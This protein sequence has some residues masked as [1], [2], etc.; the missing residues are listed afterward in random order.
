MEEKTNEPDRRPIDSASSDVPVAFF[1]PFER[2][3]GLNPTRRFFYNPKW[4]ATLGDAASSVQSSV[5]VLRSGRRRRRK[6]MKKKSSSSSPSTKIFL[7]EKEI[8]NK[9]LVRA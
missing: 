5:T 8:G 1:L 3:K 9:V 7:E 2:K 4:T 6:G